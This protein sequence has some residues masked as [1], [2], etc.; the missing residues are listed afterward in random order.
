ML[1]GSSLSLLQLKSCQRRENQMGDTAPITK[2][3]PVSRYPA[4]IHATK[5]FRELAIA[6]QSDAIAFYLEGE[7]IKY[8]NDTDRE[9][10]FR[11]ADPDTVHLLFSTYLLKS[12]S[13]CVKDKN[14]ISTTSLDVT[15]RDHVLLLGRRRRSIPGISK[16][17][18]R[19]SPSYSFQI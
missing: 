11:F 9:L 4:K 8:R 18:C 6:T 15:F 19:L 10:A 17:T 1:T 7:D 12:I 3:P 14:Q 5:V 16:M 13:I 2:Y